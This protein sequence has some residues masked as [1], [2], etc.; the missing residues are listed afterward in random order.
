MTVID[1][2]KRAIQTLRARRSAPYKRR[3]EAGW[4]RRGTRLG[5]MRALPGIRSVATAPPSSPAIQRA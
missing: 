5:Q 4:E 3:S 2:I 1:D